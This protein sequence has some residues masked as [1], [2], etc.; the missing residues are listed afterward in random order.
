M[1][2]LLSHPAPAAPDSFHERRKTDTLALVE[3]F[4]GI[5]KHNAAQFEHLMS[6]NVNALWREQW[7]TK[8]K[9]FSVENV[10]TLG[11]RDI[12]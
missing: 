9:V 4:P 2:L 12:F 1:L 11:I 3:E 5:S 8:Y 10:L 6:I 7:N